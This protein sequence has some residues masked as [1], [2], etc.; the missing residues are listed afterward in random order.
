MMELRGFSFLKYPMFLTDS[1]F[2]K[3][4]KRIEALGLI[5]GFCLLVYTLGQRELRQTL[6]R[7]KTGVKN[8]LGRFTDRPTLRW[9]FQCFQ[10]VQVFVIQAI[11]QTS[12]LT[13][14]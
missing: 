13:N 2:L 8:Q 5:M 14:E 11:K 9:I 4:P 6:K 3:S 1:V 12:N 7:M 10:S